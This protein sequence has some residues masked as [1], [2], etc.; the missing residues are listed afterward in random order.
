[1]K[2]FAF[3]FARGGS[4]RIKNKNLQKIKNKTLLEITINQAFIRPETGNIERMFDL[5]SHTVDIKV[6]IGSTRAKSPSAELQKDLQLLGAG[7]IDRTQVILNMNMIS[8][9]NY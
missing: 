7:I 5:I 3:I 1:M 6:V 4:K 9:N 2:N 8:F